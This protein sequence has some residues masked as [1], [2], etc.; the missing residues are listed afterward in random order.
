MCASVV[1]LLLDTQVC[2]GDAMCFMCVRL[3]DGQEDDAMHKNDVSF[4]RSIVSFSV[5]IFVYLSVSYNFK[6]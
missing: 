6:I 4:K 3:G 5:K 1:F 2:L